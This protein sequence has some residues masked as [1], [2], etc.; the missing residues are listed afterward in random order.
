MFIEVALVVV[1]AATFLKLVVKPQPE[2]MVETMDPPILTP[3]FDPPLERVSYGTWPGALVLGWPAKGGLYVLNAVSAVELEFLGYDRFKPVLR[4][5]PAD[6]DTAADEEAH[7]NKMRYL[8]ADW[9]E[10]EHAWSEYKRELPPGRLGEIIFATGWPAEGGVWI[11]I[12]DEEIGGKKHAG[13]LF[14]AYTMEE[15]CNI[16]KQLGGTFY[17]NPK[18]CPSLDLP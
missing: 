10:S 4:P 12:D 9:W 15:R 2:I 5:D 1:A 14:N 18:D 8:G 7:C 13:M 3:Y 6:P 17:A 11:L 16:I